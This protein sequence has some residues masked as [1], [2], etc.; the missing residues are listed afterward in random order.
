[1]EKRML[2]KSRHMLKSDQKHICFGGYIEVHLELKIPPSHGQ[3]FFGS[4]VDLT[5]QL[6]HGDF[7]RNQKLQESEPLHIM[8]E[9]YGGKF[10]ATLGLSA[11]KAIEY[12][13]L[14]LKLEVVYQSSLM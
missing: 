4:K 3:S 8:A 11:L 13:K 5:I 6:V 2:Q 7:N 14:K 9:S 12:G 1:M 10:A